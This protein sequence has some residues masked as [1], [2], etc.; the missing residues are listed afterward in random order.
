MCERT[1]WS[2][3]TVSVLPHVV[4]FGGFVD[5]GRTKQKDDGSNPAEVRRAGVADAERSHL[6]VKL[7][8]GARVTILAA[9]SA[10]TLGW[11]P[12]LVPV[13]HTR[14]GRGPAAT[15]TVTNG[16]SP[17]FCTAYLYLNFLGLRL[18]SL[19]L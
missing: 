11:L 5:L 2:P 15:V 8:L 16:G 13:F 7:L 12:P 19:L 14:T 6:W 3:G 18:R 4:A 17:V 1:K 10:V 9:V